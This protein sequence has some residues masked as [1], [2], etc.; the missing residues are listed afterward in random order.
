MNKMIMLIILQRITE[1]WN[2]GLGGLVLGSLILYLKGMG[3]IMFR[4]SG[5]YY[6]AAAR[7]KVLVARSLMGFRGANFW[8]VGPSKT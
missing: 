7:G 5:F 4:F 8:S 6:H 1:S 2:V 3:T